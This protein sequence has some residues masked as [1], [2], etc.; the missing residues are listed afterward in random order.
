MSLNESQLNQYEQ[1]GYL[2]LRKAL[3]DELLDTLEHRF[4]ELV[5]EWGG[6]TFS[7]AQLPELAQFLLE[8]RE[9]ETKLYDGIRTF[10]SF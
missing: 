2:I 4:L 3:P 6:R 9:L 10:P 1:D 5:K 7:S 8:N